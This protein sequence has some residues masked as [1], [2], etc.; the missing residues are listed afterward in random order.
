MVQVLDDD[1]FILHECG[2]ILKYLCSKYG[3]YD[4]LYP[5]TFKERAEVNEY[6][7]KMIVIAMSQ[8][9]SILISILH[10]HHRNE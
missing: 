7:V 10:Q 3:K 8:I 6:M 9:L 1:G 4:Q 2:A 5:L